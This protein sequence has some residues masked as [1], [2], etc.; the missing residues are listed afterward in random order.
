MGGK[1]KRWNATASQK[2]SSVCVALHVQLSHIHPFFSVTLPSKYS[3][4]AYP[5]HGIES[6]TVRIL[7]GGS[8][9]RN[10]AGVP[11]HPYQSPSITTPASTREGKGEAWKDRRTKISKKPYKLLVLHITTFVL[12]VAIWKIVEILKILKTQCA[13]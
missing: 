11:H 5:A 4:I 13:M 10:A 3:L 12:H 6:G 9:A 2:Y 1:K 8:T 7:G